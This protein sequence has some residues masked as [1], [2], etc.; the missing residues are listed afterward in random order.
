MPLPSFVY[1]SIFTFSPPTLTFVLLR[2]TL[3]PTTL[4]LART[5]P[6]YPHRTLTVVYGLTMTRTCRCPAPARSSFAFS[7]THTRTSRAVPPSSFLLSWRP[8]IDI[9]SFF[10][11]DT[12]AHTLPYWSFVPLLCSLRLPFTHQPPSWHSSTITPFTASFVIF[13]TLFRCFRDLF[14]FDRL[15]SS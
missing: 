8:A 3:N 1:P 14:S 5:L 11:I 12:A 6:P 7:P 15:F 10:L 9:A 13:I 4:A 2:L